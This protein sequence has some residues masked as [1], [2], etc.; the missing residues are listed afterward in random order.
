VA[1]GAAAAAAADLCGLCEER[2]NL[3][4]VGCLIGCMAAAASANRQAGGLCMSGLCFEPRLVT[5]L[6]EEHGA[7]PGVAISFDSF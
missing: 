2:Y 5:S 1:G 6:W 4:P 7:S 3:G